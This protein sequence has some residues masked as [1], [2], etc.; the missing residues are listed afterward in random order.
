[1]TA[2]E[3]REPEASAGARNY[4][5]LAYSRAELTDA[6]REGYAILIDFVMT[7]DFQS[8]LDEM[9]GL[10]PVQR[11]GFVVDVLLDAD[12]LAERGVVVPDG[13]MIQRSAFGDRRPTLFAVKRWL[14]ERF[15]DVWENV[16]LTFDN[17]YPDEAVSREA[18]VAWRAPLPIGFQAQ[19]MA[20]GAPLETVA[21]DSRGTAKQE[22]EA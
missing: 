6:M 8:V 17:E 2:T 9:R 5:H 3:V 13:I 21:P 18:E 20:D 10:P 1:M 12:A 4:D 15:K 16:N 14:P 22:E 11:P 7:P 19:K